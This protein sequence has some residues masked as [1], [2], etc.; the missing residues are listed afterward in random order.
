MIQVSNPVGFVCTHLY[1]RTVFMLWKDFNKLQTI[2]M[3]PIY[4][5]GILL[6]SWSNTVETKPQKSHAVFQFLLQ[7]SVH[8]GFTSAPSQPDL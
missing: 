6:A 5:D 8:H 3:A 7:L 4:H 1:C 2:P